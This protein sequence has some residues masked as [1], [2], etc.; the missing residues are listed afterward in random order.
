MM[1]AKALSSWASPSRACQWVG[2]ALRWEK[3]AP[4]QSV[5]RRMMGM[6]QEP[7]WLYRG[8]WPAASG[9]CS[10]S[11]KPEIGTNKQQNE[12][13]RVQVELS[14]CSFQSVPGAISSSCHSL[15]TPCLLRLLRWVASSS[16][17]SG[18]CSKVSL[19]IEPFHLGYKLKKSD[20]L[21]TVKFFHLPHWCNCHINL[22]V[23]LTIQYNYI[24]KM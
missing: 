14:I 4:S 15:M 19:A 13:G 3:G 16:R 1:S 22:L 24:K 11:R 10:R 8:Q 17:K 12:L 9:C 5:G 21:P 18:K 23:S 20:K 7:G 2:K 6:T